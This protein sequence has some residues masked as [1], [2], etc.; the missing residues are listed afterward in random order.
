M[1]RQIPKSVQTIYSIRGRRILSLEDADSRVSEYESLLD[2]FTLI[3]FILIFAAFLYVARS[4][5]SDENA[6]DVAA[7]I[8]QKG[9]GTTSGS[10]ALPKNVLLMVL[11]RENGQ[12]KLLISDG[13]SG[14]N[15]VEIVTHET[16]VNLLV[17]F[18]SEFAAPRI[19][20]F[21]AYDGKES[22]NVALIVDI[23]HWL[24]AHDYNFKLYFTQ[25]NQ[26]NES[27]K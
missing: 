14:T 11:Y 1:K 27:P 26:S 15:K 12:D 4:N 9:N 3:S 7:R 13:I 25:N 5:G 24:A 22:A 6:S 18:T 17:K 23:E 19:I 20:N 21:A 10:Q 2:L 8:T 16:I